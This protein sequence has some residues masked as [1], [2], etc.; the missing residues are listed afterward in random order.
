VVSGVGMLIAIVATCLLAGMEF[1][2]DRHR[3]RDRRRSSE[4]WPRPAV[5]MTAM[6]EMVGLFNGFG[7]LASCS[8][9]GR[10]STSGRSWAG[11]DE[12]YMRCSRGRG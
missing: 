9:R 8:S 5:K 11:P 4:R 12:G 2:L 6:P 7:G 3:L 10:S 1:H